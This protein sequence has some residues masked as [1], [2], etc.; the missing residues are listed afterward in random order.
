MSNYEQHEFGKLIPKMLSKQFVDLQNSI[1]TIGLQVPIVLFEGKVLDGWNRYTACQNIT[2]NGGHLPSPIRYETLLCDASQA[3]QFVLANNL[4]RRHIPEDE[5]VKLALDIRKK[6][7]KLKPETTGEQLDEQAAKAAGT[8]KRTV[9]RA[10]E[11]ERKA[12]K[13]VVKAMEE[14]TITPGTALKLAKVDPKAAAKA[15]E[16]AKKAGKARKEDV[17]A[18]KGVKDANGKSVPK[19]LRDVFEDAEQ[20]EH[21]GTLLKSVM[22]TLKACSKNYPGVYTQA[23]I[24]NIEGT[25][26]VLQAEQATWLC[27][28]CDGTGEVEGKKCNVCKA[29]GWHPYASG[30][31]PKY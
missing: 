10:T 28:A 3:L 15:V 6:L 7:E 20:L 31:E 13:E 27:K 17:D 14:G 22:K 25:A 1:E 12:P 2:E 9:Q 19:A 4:S 11:V 26:A 5:R 16:K 23:I 8:S 18:A 30:K 29:R 24:R 21:A